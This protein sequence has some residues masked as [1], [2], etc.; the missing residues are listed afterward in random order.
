[1]KIKH[2]KEFYKCNELWKEITEIES[3]MLKY[4]DSAKS[5]DLFDLNVQLSFKKLEFKEC[6]KKLTP[7]EFLRLSK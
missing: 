6:A 3:D 5:E 7:K 1:M 2:Q 4:K